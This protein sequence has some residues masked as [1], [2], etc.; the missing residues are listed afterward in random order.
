MKTVNL[1]DFDLQRLID[2]TS[3]T[4][5]VKETGETV[6]ITFAEGSRKYIAA[7]VKYKEGGL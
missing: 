3:T 6:L 1:S 4:A 5:I 7:E 2:G